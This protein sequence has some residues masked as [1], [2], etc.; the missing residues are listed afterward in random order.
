MSDHIPHDFNALT[1]FL[2]VHDAHG[3]IGWAKEALAAK[4][5]FVHE[6]DGR[7]VHAEVEIEG[8]VLELSEGREEWPAKPASFHLFVPDPDAAVARALEVGGELLYEVADQEYGE[9]S[10]GVKDPFGNNWYLARVTDQE[11]RAGM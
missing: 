7:V 9:R 5:R 6:E 1:P 11:R 3:F 10:G 4:E 8:C 2:H